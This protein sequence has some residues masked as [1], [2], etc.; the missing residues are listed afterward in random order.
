VPMDT[1]RLQTELLVHAGRLLL[2]F[3]ESTGAIHRALEATAEVLTDQACHVTVYYGGVAVSLAGEAPVL[4]PVRE[5]RYNTA[6]QAGVHAVLEQMRRGE[7]DLAMAL[8]RLRKVEADTPRHSGRVAIPVFAI[9]AASL[10]GLL[11]ADPG[12][13]LVTGLSAGLG[14][15]ARQELARRHF[16]VLTLPLIAAFLGA[17][18][19]GLAIRLGWTRTPELVLIVPA[20]MLVP[21][22][23][24]ING[25]LDLVD[26][27][28][29]MSMARLGLA[30]GILLANALGIVFGIE[31]M[32]PGVHLPEQ[33]ANVEHINLVS[34]LVLA[35]VATCGFAV[36]YNSPWKQVGMAALGGMAGHGLRYLALEAGCRLQVATFLGGLAVGAVSGWLARS[37]KT[38]F[39]VI[40]F[41]GAVTMMPGLH[42]Y[43]ALGGALQLARQANEIAPAAMAGALGNALQS[44][45]VVGGLTLGLVLGDR[46]VPTVS[47]AIVSPKPSS[48]ALNTDEAG[49]AGGG[50]T[51]CFSEHANR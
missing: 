28:L 23:H 12:T 38:P 27:Y 4:L 36:F 46:V 8:A 21:G 20:L 25:V 44:C 45:L 24:L 42:I 7:V 6:V 47:G 18:V 35:G 37:G 32:L 33:G 11:G 19:G 17:V 26:N 30:T 13:V 51:D 31:L 39:A 43:R 40:A 5:L 10:A 48:A 16:N 3:N 22:P 14:L 34:D 15:L 9:A 1:R 49:P 29:P 50:Q 2:E 41:A